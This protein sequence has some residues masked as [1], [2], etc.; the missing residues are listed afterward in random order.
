MQQCT[1]N[2]KA[3]Q[4]GWQPFSPESA[5]RL[6]HYDPP[7]ALQ[8]MEDPQFPF[9][10]VCDRPL[11][12][13]DKKWRP[14]DRGMLSRQLVTPLQYSSANIFHGGITETA[15]VISSARSITAW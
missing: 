6:L 11:R 10:L 7:K 15:R 3:N 9:Q 2:W 1:K 8:L 4:P 13:Y 12:M 14:K 5:F